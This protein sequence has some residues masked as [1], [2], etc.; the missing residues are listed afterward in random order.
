[1]ALAAGDEVAYT[2]LATNVAY[3]K[4]NGDFQFGIVNDAAGVDVL[5]ANGTLSEGIL[6]TNLDL[7][8]ATGTSPAE[9]RVVRFTAQES[10]EYDAI[11]LRVYNRSPNGAGTPV[12]YMLLQILATGARIEVPASS[13]FVLTGR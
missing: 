1:M 6:A 12:A 2:Q 8:Q 10:P 11:V 9:G 3:A 5:W 13:V 7:I 4:R